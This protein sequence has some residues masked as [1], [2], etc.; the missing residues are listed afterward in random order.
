[1]TQAFEVLTLFPELVEAAADT[2]VIGRGCR[3]GHLAIRAHQLR[4]FTGGSPHPID[5]SP[6]GGGPGMVM[7]P[8][9]IFAAVE[10]CAE[11]FPGIHRILLTPQGKRFDQASARRLATQG[12]P[13]LLFCARYE[14]VDERARC[15]F[16]EEISIGDYVLTGGELAALAVI[17]AVGRLI[18]GVLGSHSSTD[19]ESFSRPDRLEY[20]QYTRPA[21][22][23][24]VTVPT[25]LTSGN[26]AA[27]R[28]WR[29][30]QALARTAARRPDLLHNDEE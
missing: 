12:K 23:R 13:I 10:H 22:F 4:D 1:M 28:R 11:Q 26:H 18:P 21:E 25:V 5:D 16:D 14:G 6:Y 8:E 29:E 17:D 30:E 15:L 3:E 27:I 7:R 19:E 2:G 20:P 9:P 24:G